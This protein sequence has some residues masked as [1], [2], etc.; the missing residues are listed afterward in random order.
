MSDYRRC[1]YCNQEIEREADRCRHCGSWLQ[2]EETPFQSAPSADRLAPDSDFGSAPPWPE[3]PSRRRNTRGCL[4]AALVVAAVAAVFLA[5]IGGIVFLVFGALRSAD[6]TEQAVQAARENPA[7]VQALGEP[8]ETG[9][10]VTGSLETGGAGGEA[11]LSIPVSGPRGA[12]TIHVQADRRGG[13]WVFLYLELET[14]SGE[15]I[16]L[17]E[18]AEAPLEFRAAVE[19]TLPGTSSGWGTPGVPGGCGSDGPGPGRAPGNEESGLCQNCGVIS[20][21]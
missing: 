3:S 1:P 21:A 12:G 6:I 10:F 8:I 17:L 18:S 5:F 11:D 14:G 4:I 13:E 15:R 2:E 20:S 19:A 16:D 7:A 9:W